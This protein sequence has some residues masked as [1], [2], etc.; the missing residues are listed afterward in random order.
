MR[1][2][3]QWLVGVRSFQVEVR[4]PVTDSSK[5][6]PGVAHAS[7]SEAID[8]APRSYRPYLHEALGCY[9][10]HLYRAAILM[11]WSATMSHLYDT[12]GDHP[13]GIKAFEQANR[14]QFGQSTAYRKVRKRDDFMYLRDRSFIELSEKA[15]LYNKSTR[16]ML[17][18]RLDLRNRCGH[19]TGYTVGREETVIF[20]ESLCLNV[21]SGSLLNWG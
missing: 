4:E 5:E 6:A 2:T 16:Q 15:G 17:I 12:I 20:V 13:G 14:A 9:E 21:L 3:E 18:D 19:P 1:P 11:V 8:K 7:L 10:N